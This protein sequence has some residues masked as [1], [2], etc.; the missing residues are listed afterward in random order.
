L[1]PGFLLNHASYGVFP[2][3]LL[4]GALFNKYT[5]VWTASPSISLGLS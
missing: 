3:K 5:A 2:F 4:V 1:T